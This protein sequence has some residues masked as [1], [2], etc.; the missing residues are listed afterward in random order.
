VLPGNGDGTFGAERDVAL[1]QRAVGAA[2]ADL[3]RDGKPDLIALASGMKELVWF[4]NP[5]WQ[6]HVIAGNQNRMIN[7][8][9]VEVDGRPH[10]VLASEFANEAKNSIGVVSLLTPGADV[11]QPWTAREIDRLTTSHRLRV[12]DIDGS[13]KTIVVNAPLTGAGAAAPDYRDHTPLVYYR[14]GEWKRELISAANEGV[15]HGIYIV[16]WDGDG[17][18]EILT[19][20]F[21]GIHL[22]KFG[23][24]GQWTRTAITQ[25]DP[26]AWPKSGSSDVAVGK[27]GKR[28]F[29]AAIEP[30]H[31]NQA[32]IYRNGKHGWD[33]QV[34]DDSLVE[35]HTILAADLNGDGRDEVIAGYRGKGRSVNLYYAD[36]KGRHWSKQLLD[37][38]G[39]AANACTV[40]DFNG[41]HRPDIACIGGATA[42]LKWY[43]NLGP[44]GK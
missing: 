20:S 24:D 33:R 32:V 40:A 28:R 25:G 12:A 4:E 11:R 35:G 31:G 19:A 7:C 39:I 6:R 36:A 41:D 14:P 26:A 18:D 22:Y 38:G 34:I 43:E 16:D 13:G 23:K 27:L 42:N 30:W 44:A 17:R 37:D 1:T 10:I 9:V 21:V 29:L 15:V 2:V 8:A 3:N 5:T